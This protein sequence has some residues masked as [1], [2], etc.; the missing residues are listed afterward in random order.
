MANKPKSMRDIEAENANRDALSGAPGSHP[1]GT[2]VGAALGGAAAGAAAGA[3]TGPIG[4]AAGAVVG[5]VAGGYAGK[6][7]AEEIDPTVE[8]A[9]WE[10]EYP[11]REYYDADVEYETIAPAYQ[12]GWESRAK[13]RDRTWDEV[14]P[15]LRE[16]WQKTNRELAWDRARQASR[17]AWDRIERGLPGDADG[18]GR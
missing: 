17:D 10:Q 5:A 18:D 15:Q 12:Y 3:A 8:N 6:A 16:D 13:Y 11:R 9:Y 2:G 4:A 7:V 1:V 14:E